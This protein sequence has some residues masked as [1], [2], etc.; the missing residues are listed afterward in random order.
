MERQFP[1]IDKV[2]TGHRIK[3]LMTVRGL[4]VKDVQNYLGFSTQ[5]A[6]YHWLSGRSLPTI[7][8]IYALSALLQVPLDDLICGNRKILDQQ[9]VGTYHRLKVYRRRLQELM[10]A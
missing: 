3:H 4:N 10:A 1:V 2:R 8:N 9:Y 6:V 7:D 5:Q